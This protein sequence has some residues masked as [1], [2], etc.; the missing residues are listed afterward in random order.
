MKQVKDM[1]QNLL[2][3]FDTFHFPCAVCAECK[4]KVDAEPPVN[5]DDHAYVYAAFVC[6]DDHVECFQKL[7]DLQLLDCTHRFW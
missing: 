3:I 2:T 6:I 7:V 5:D 1:I 4:A